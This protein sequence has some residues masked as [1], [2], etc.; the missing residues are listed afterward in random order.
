MSIQLSD[1]PLVLDYA[2]QR[3]EGNHDR[4]SLHILLILG[5]IAVISVLP[6]FQ[7]A[8]AAEH[9]IGDANIAKHDEDP[10]RAGDGADAGDD[11]AG[12]EDHLA[13]IVQAADEAI[14]AGIN[15]A[16]GVRLFG[17]TTSATMRSSIIS[18]AVA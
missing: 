16:A 10:L 4:H 18:P 7:T 14:K 3:N 2:V 5:I 1:E 8:C 17:G 6:E 11:A 9:D 15:E 12:P 13:Q